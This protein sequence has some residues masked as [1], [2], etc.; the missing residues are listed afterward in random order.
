MALSLQCACGARFEVEPT[1]A[2]QTV[3]CPECQKPVPAPAA[4][5]AEPLRTS[6]WALASFVM[7]LVL[8]FTGVGSL[9]AALFGLVALRQIA[10]RRDKYTGAGYA[11]FGIVVGTLFTG[12]FVFAVSRQE[13][14]GG[15]FIRERLNGDQVDRTGPLEVDRPADGFRI[16]R[17][18]EAWGV[19]GPKLV[20]EWDLDAPLVLAE[21]KRN[22]FIDVSVVQPTHQSVDQYASQLLSQYRPVQG[23]APRDLNAPRDFVSRADQRLPDRDGLEVHELQFNVRQKSLPLTFLIWVVR[24]KG[25]N[26]LFVLR[27]WSTQNRFD[28]VKADVRAAFESFHTSP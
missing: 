2:G 12:L 19:A 9:L 22:A 1:L 20:A 21:L 17:P 8:A 6:G 3:S 11:V 24:E 26:R 28:S 25:D 10:V 13:L 18:S 5:A 23:V 4:A 16:T 7:S 15:D 14:L 27:G